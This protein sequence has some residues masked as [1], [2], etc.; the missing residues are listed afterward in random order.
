MESGSGPKQNN[1]K[2]CG[3]FL[4]R[5]IET[6]W[7]GPYVRFSFAFDFLSGLLVIA[8]TIIYRRL[9]VETSY[10]CF[11]TCFRWTIIKSSSVKE[12]QLEYEIFL[13]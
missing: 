8:R 9:N 3:L 2:H 10:G 4:V 12:S 11:E 13:Q 7:T 1:D 5:Y 6:I